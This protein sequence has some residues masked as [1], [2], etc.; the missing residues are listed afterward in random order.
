MKDKVERLRKIK[1]EIDS[2]YNSLDG[3]KAYIDQ[4][5]DELDEAGVLI[6]NAALNME[7]YLSESH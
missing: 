1:E 6:E 4:A 2:I 5:I 7:A 3:S